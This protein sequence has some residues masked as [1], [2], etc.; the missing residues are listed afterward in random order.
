MVHFI[1]ELVKLAFL[2]IGGFSCAQPQMQVLSRALRRLRAAQSGVARRAALT[3]KGPAQILT[4]GLG[5]VLAEGVLVNGRIPFSREALVRQ[6]QGLTAETEGSGLR[7][8]GDVCS[9][10][11]V[12][13]VNSLF[14]YFH[15]LCCFDFRRL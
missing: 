1:A 12:G 8:A 15:H 11:A 2:D 13:Q 9:L 3:L 4:E 14:N 7:G 5:D 6:Q 10:N